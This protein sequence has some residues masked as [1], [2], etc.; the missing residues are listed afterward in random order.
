MEKL[1]DLFGYLSVLLR[2]GGL[3]ATTM[4]LGSVAFLVLLAS[5]SA[6]RLPMHGAAVV[7][8]GLRVLRW[9]A[10]GSV[11]ATLAA[12]GL[13]LLALAGTL[14]LPF[15]E[16]LGASFLKSGALLAVA[17]AVLFALTFGPPPGRA[18]QVLMVMLALLIL[19]A[20]L[21][22]SHAVAR[23]GERWMMLL[24]SAAHLLGAALWLGG[25]PAFLLGL[26]RTDGSEESRLLGSAYS[27]L[28][29]AGVALLLVGALAIGIGFIG[30]VDAVYGTAYGA[31]AATKTVLLACLLLLGLGNFLLIRNATAGTP[32][33]MR[34]V[35]R[36]VEAEI[37]IG[38]VVLMAA[39]SITSQPPAVDLTRDRASWEE[40]VER[41]T[42]RL[43]RM[44]TPRHDDLA[45]PALQAR[46]DA[47]QTREDDATRLKAFVPG[48]GEPPPRNAFDV[49]WSEYNHHWAG[50]VVLLVGLAA[51]AERTGRAPW[52]RHWPL[53]FLGLA[54]F[55]LLRSDPETWPLGDIGFFESFLD[56]EVTQHRLFVLLVVAF[57]LFEWRAS[58]QA[59]NS[60]GRV[61]VFPVLVVVGSALLLTHSH[62]I[63]NL[64]EQ[65]L[66]EISHLLL[67]VM[68][69][70]AGCARWLELRADGRLQAAAGWWWPSMFVLI[71]LLLLG[72]REA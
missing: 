55:L 26:R 34:R 8:G 62:A 61:L 40:V 15:T 27:R 54:G 3:V 65:L 58:S 35:Q 17:G 42:P 22:S 67:G 71:G 72:Y 21:G 16:L 37:A 12:D 69:L 10:L 24:A 25:L 44:E 50:L 38:V 39:S 63:A 20:L 57:A 7:A 18:G 19:L 5:P 59:R 1:I 68:G 29:V 11:V 64:K 13:V 14:E 30:S 53:L 47:E 23:P 36:L 66:I 49:A 43:P 32:A 4:T 56:P 41:L 48:G 45:I 46:L 33:S 2:A 9:A 52:C 6:A 28:A 51:A 70:L 60:T 31:M